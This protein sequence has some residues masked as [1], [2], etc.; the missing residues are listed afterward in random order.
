MENRSFPD[1]IRDLIARN[2]L[3]AALQQLRDLLNEAILQSAL[4]PSFNL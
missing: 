3:R 2:D 1:H 4:E